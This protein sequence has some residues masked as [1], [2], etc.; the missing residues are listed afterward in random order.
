MFA[1]LAKHLSG[2]TG[3]KNKEG[4]LVQ[5]AAQVLVGADSKGVPAFR[6]PGV[7][8]TRCETLDAAIGVGGV[9]MSR[10]TVLTGGEGCG[11]TTISGHACAEVQA[12]GGVALYVDNEH[13]V[14][15][16][17]FRAIG[18]NLDKFLIT[19]PS[20]I[21][22]SFTIMNELILKVL[23]EHPGVPVLAVLDSLNATKSSKEYEEDGT[24]D[25][26][27]S[28]QGG[29]GATA[30][31]MSANLPKLLRVISQQKVAVLAISQPREKIGGYGGRDLIAGGN[32]PKFYAALAIELYRK[33]FWEESAR[34]IG[35]ITVAKVFKNQVSIPNRD[36]EIPI[37]WGLGV[38]TSKSLI[39]QACKIGVVAAT[40][41]GRFEMASSVEGKPFK[42]QG[43]KGWHQLT[44]DNP[45]LL[46]YL[47]QTVRSGYQRIES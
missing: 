9:P 21:E 2:I 31:F 15:L 11:K 37:R 39:D 35:Q 19:Q 47:K 13:K 28:N 44:M 27:E 12:M 23:R 10:F 18:V 32:A 14:D 25:F 20:T 29:L 17:Y 7:I 41:G 26:S 5:A 45:G 40:G 4:E 30:R 24:A 22:D 46:D 16:D 33:G 42:W 6:I 34:K 36:C 3:K 1:D 43:T 38:D 8:S